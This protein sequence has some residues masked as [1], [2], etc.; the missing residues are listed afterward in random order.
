MEVRVLKDDGCNTTCRLRLFRSNS[1]LLDI[2][3]TEIAMSHSKIRSEEV[4]R[5]IVIDAAG[6]IV[7]HF[8]R[9]NWAVFDTR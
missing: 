9:S 2:R 3:D 6:Q 4:R 8:N 5:K 1:H 7:E